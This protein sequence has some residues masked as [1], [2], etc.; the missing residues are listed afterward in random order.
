MFR[1]QLRDIRFEYSSATSKYY[2]SYKWI[3]SYL[4]MCYY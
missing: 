2:N 4:P 3:E 1:K